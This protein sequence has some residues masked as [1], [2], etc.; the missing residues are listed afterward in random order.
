MSG[1]NFQTLGLGSFCPAGVSYAWPVCL[2]P[3]PL[4]NT[5]TPTVNRTKLNPLSPL[6][7]VEY[8]AGHCTGG[9]RLSKTSTSPPRAH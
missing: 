7:R 2:H 5:P 6:H 3:H 9:L 1:F 4:K 8:G